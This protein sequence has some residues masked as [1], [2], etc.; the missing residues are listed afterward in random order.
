MDLSQHITYVNHILQKSAA[1]LFFFFFCSAVSFFQLFRLSFA[2]RFTSTFFFFFSFL[3][4]F[5]FFFYTVNFLLLFLLSDFLL[6]SRFFFYCKGKPD[7]ERERDAE[8]GVV[9][10]EAVPVE[11]SR[12]GYAPCVLDN[13]RGEAGAFPM[14]SPEGSLAA[15][16]APASSS[17]HVTCEGSLHDACGSPIRP[18]FTGSNVDP[19][20][21]PVVGHPEPFSSPTVAPPLASPSAIHSDGR[22]SRRHGSPVP[23]SFF[24]PM[25]FRLPSSSIS[26]WRRVHRRRK[27]F[28]QLSRGARRTS[29]HSCSCSR[30]GKNSSKSRSSRPPCGLHVARSSASHST[31]LSTSKGE[32]NGVVVIKPATGGEDDKEEAEEGKE[33]GGGDPSI[34]GVRCF[35]FSSSASPPFL[36]DPAAWREMVSFVSPQRR[37]VEKRGKGGGGGGEEGSVGVPFAFVVVVVVPPGPE[38]RPPPGVALPCPPATV[39]RE[40]TEC[41]SLARSLS[42]S[43]CGRQ[44]PP[45]PPP[46]PR[47][48][49][50]VDNEGACPLKCTTLSYSA[51][52][53]VCKCAV[54]ACSASAIAA[55]QRCA[56][57]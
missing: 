49:A 24:A 44:P 1:F 20:L 11:L 2:A 37:V 40:N 42:L 54:W 3:L 31:F 56:P 51:S 15:A 34:S 46:P 32:T 23:S 28:P 41:I 38:R 7:Y 12:D 19:P 9:V 52:T 39:S 30:R 26:F 43:H 48:T 16:A 4:L 6:F 57:R 36:P 18:A 33:V 29:A 8:K 5:F 13:F 21:V 10:V 55:V 17:S 25:F 27:A 50:A 53:T 35:V 45:P 14:T 47:S 22:C